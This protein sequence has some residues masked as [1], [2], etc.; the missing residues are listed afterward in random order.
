MRPW[1]GGR[2]VLAP[3][4]SPALLR[5]CTR[6]STKN[7]AMVDGKPGS[8]LCPPRPQL[9]G[10]HPSCLD[11]LLQQFRDFYKSLRIVELKR[12]PPPQSGPALHV[13]SIP[14]LL[15]LL[16][17]PVGAWAI[18]GAPALAPSAFSL[19]LSC[20]GWGVGGCH[21]HCPCLCCQRRLSFLPAC[22]AGGAAALAWMCVP[23][24]RACTSSS[25]SSSSSSRR[26]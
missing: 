9:P 23:L 19:V 18:L 3:A 21:I 17:P 16:G 13:Q 12:T 14:P 24:P 6:P 11:A 5:V 2:A 1:A 8:P 10:N 4:V 22:S 7:T 25:S 20:P 15:P 26:N